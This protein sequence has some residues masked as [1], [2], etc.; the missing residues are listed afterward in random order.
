[1]SHRGGREGERGDDAKPLAGT[2]AGALQRVDQGQGGCAEEDPK[3]GAE[4]DPG[5][6]RGAGGERSG[7]LSGRGEHEEEEPAGQ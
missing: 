5:E 1:M 6:G 7:R 4:R 2:G 3:P